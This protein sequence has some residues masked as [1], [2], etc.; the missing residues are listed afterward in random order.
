MGMIVGDVA[1]AELA[2]ATDNP[3]NIP[4]K[5]FIPMYR[6]ACRMT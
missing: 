5:H 3:A 6:S 4:L 1:N 2:A